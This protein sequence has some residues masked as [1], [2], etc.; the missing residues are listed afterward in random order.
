[1]SNR[2]WACFDCRQSIRRPA[3]YGDEALAEVVA[4]PECGAHC[5]YIGYK[6]PLPPR[7]DE[8]AWASLRA[9][10][11]REEQER[12]QLLLQAKVRARHQIEKEI[13]R[14][15]ERPANA[16][17]SKLIRGLRRRLGGA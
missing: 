6:I 16:E 15:E 11:L 17:R 8:K 3:K 14:V 5:V 2:T 4:C 10:L 9:Q 13:S 1:M 12:Q 7:R